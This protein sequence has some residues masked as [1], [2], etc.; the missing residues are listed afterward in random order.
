MARAFA[1]LKRVSIGAARRLQK[2]LPLPIIE[3][4]I[5]HFCT[6]RR[7][8][9]ILATSILAAPVAV[10][11]AV[12]QIQQ[13]PGTF[14][15]ISL[16]TDI[17]QFSQYPD[18]Q[19]LHI[20]DS[21]QNPLPWR[22]VPPAVL[23]NQTLPQIKSRSLNF[24]PIAADASAAD[25]RQ[26]YNTHISI[27]GDELTF[28]RPAAD[29]TSSSAAPEFYLI[30]ARK[31]QQGITALVID[32]QARQCSEYL[33]VTLQGS[34]NLQD[35]QTIED[36]TLVQIHQQGHSLKHNRIQT[37]LPE[38]RFEFLRLK[39]LRSAENVHINKITAEEEFT[40]E[41][42][43]TPPKQTWNVRGEKAK[44]QNSLRRENS[45]NTADAVTAWEFIRTEITPAQEI[46]LDLGQ[47]PYGDTLHLFSRNNPQHPWR[48][49][50]AGIWYQTQV[51]AQW[52]QSDPIILARNCDRYWRL[53]LAPNANLSHPPQL[54][55]A[56]TPDALQIIA[57]QH[58]P[59]N[60]V[61]TRGEVK[62]FAAEQVF[63]HIIATQTPSWQPTQL[64]PLAIPAGSTL[65]EP[66]YFNWKKIGFWACLLLAVAILFMLTIRLVQQLK[67]TP[68][69]PP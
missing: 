5:K 22:L 1:R 32:W 66:A 41:V 36:A 57:N 56:W 13:A 10:A 45:H 31:L 68:A 8:Y 17:Y 47:Q 46:T 35:W 67:H 29:T 4:V 6:P 19:D 16:P 60:L 25:L 18:L 64:E 63:N 23:K 62:S 69:D 61:F 26:V 53:E 51:G 24:F 49:Q 38:D 59:F 43:Q 48:L 55:F 44:I 58:L 40:A 65:A 37:L 28:S 12:F 9:S 54:A 20:L 34:K 52:Q 50:H 42:V 3:P 21:N 33:Q 2:L 15:E 39:V 30:D 11:Q 27:Q 7:V 14:I